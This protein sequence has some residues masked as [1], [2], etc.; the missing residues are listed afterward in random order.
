MVEEL[1]EVLDEHGYVALEA[2]PRPGNDRS[3][4]DS[5]KAMMWASEAAI[6]LVVGVPDEREFSVNLAHE[7]GFM[8]SQGKLL[9]PPV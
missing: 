8:Q 6:L 4:S 9:L 3:S 7:R 5:A 1:R 2:V